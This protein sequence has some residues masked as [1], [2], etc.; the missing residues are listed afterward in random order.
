MFPTPLTCQNQH[1]QLVCFP[2]FAQFLGSLT[3]SDSP[4]YLSYSLSPDIPARLRKMCSFSFV[5][6]VWWWSLFYGGLLGS[7]MF[8]ITIWTDLGQTSANLELYNSASFY[9]SDLMVEI[10]YFVHRPQHSLLCA[11][12]LIKFREVWHVQI[13]HVICFCVCCPTFPQNWQ[14]CFHSHSFLWSLWGR[15]GVPGCSQLKYRLVGHI[16]GQITP[17]PWFR[18]FANFSETLK[19]LQVVGLIEPRTSFLMAY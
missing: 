2:E 13:Y 16:L 14:T 12:K 3:C 5:F 19:F 11:P 18:K 6:M 8:P 10:W 9:L 17:L 4:C 7:R 1:F 15:H